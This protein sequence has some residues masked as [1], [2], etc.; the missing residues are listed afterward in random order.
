[1]SQHIIEL[2]C[3]GCGARVTNG[4]R[5]CEWCHRPIVISSFKDI[6][7]MEVQEA[8]KYIGVYQNTLV[9]HSENASL[10]KAVALCFL[11]LEMRDKALVEFENAIEADMNDSEAYYYAA[12]CALGGKKA[13]LNLRPVIDK[14]L[15]YIN[16]ALLIEPRGIYYYYMAYI[17]Y[18]YFAR[19]YFKTSPDWRECLQ[20]AIAAGVSDYDIGQLYVALGVSRPEVM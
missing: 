1:M 10:H 11:R 2:N 3:P 12:V 13:F 7:T 9:E 19:K 17:K 16:A 4:H 5:E 20:M 18:D 15:E 8:K 6:Q 14:A